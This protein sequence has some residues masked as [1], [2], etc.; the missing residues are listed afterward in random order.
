MDFFDGDEITLVKKDGSNYKTQAS[1]QKNTIYVGDVRFPVEIGDEIHREIP[2]L[3]ERF[4]VLDVHRLGVPGADLSHCEIKVRNIA[5]RRDTPAASI[6][7]HYHGNIGALAHGEN[8]V[9]TNSG[10]MFVG[11]AGRE[12]DSI[13][14]ERW[15]KDME[16]IAW[17][18]AEKHDDLA[19]R[20]HG[21]F[22]GL[23]ST[24]PQATTLT[25]FQEE[26][27]AAAKAAIPEGARQEAHSRMATVMEGVI[28]GS[29]HAV[30]HKLIEWLGPMLIAAATLHR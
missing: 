24:A 20:L 7:H 12:S 25:S 22:S 13:T 14:Q 15:K 23:A 8:A 6:V 10:P 17:A 1:V 29:T 19:R 27:L 2:P 30:V 21:L 4:E 3:V 28:A 18:L 11:A 9:A 5:I 26:A 16:E